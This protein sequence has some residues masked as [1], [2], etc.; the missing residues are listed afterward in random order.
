MY[1]NV[2]SK[3]HAHFIGNMGTKIKTIFKE[4]GCRVQFPHVKDDVKKSNEVVLKGSLR[5]IENARA[6][7]RV[8]N[9]I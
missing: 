9:S 7:L 4:T 8:S 6:L 5:A 3:Y 2:N 1:L